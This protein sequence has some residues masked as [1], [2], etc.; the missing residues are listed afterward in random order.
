MPRGMTHRSLTE[1][2][3]QIDGVQ[4]TAEMYNHSTRTYWKVITDGS[5]GDYTRGAEVVSPIL[6][7]DDGFAQVRKVCDALQSNNVKVNRRCGLHVHVGA[8]GK[9]ITFFRSLLKLY[10][11]YEPVLDT[12]TAPSRR[13]NVNAYCHSTKAQ[14]DLRRERIEASIDL[15]GITLAYTGGGIH[16]RF[17][18]LNLEAYWRHGTVEFRHHQG[19]VNAKKTEAWIRICLGL[20]T[21][22]DAGA[23]PEGE[24]IDALA[25]KLNMVDMLP[26]WRQR[27]LEL[28]RIVVAE[29]T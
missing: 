4:A 16:S 25:E 26:Y 8:R 6:Q 24:T 1:I 22:A 13:A 23:E 10:A 17:V 18:K 29:R 7:G 3:N 9:P 19:T 14:V 20:V 11:H 12:L 21:A 2:L 15:R 27:Q 28:N 5:L